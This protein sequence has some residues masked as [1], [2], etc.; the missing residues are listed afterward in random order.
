MIFLA[1]IW[2]LLFYA[3]P[4]Q[5]LVDIKALL[6]FIVPY[7]AA[8]FYLRERETLNAFLSLLLITLTAKTIVYFCGYI[9]KFLLYEELVIRV[10]LTA[11]VVFYPI[12]LLLC[13][14]LLVVH[15]D[16]VSRGVYLVLA[17]IIALSLFWSFGREAWF[18]TVVSTV[19]LIAIASP[20]MRRS[21]IQLLLPAL[22][23]FALLITLIRPQTWSYAI[24]SIETFTLKK[25]GTG[26][27]ET[28][29]VRVIE[30][31]NIH[32]LLVD[33]HTLLIGRG[34]GATWTDRYYPLPKKRDIYSFPLGETEH[35]FTHMVFSK[36][37][38]KFGILGSL[39]FWGA[40]LLPWIKTIGWVKHLEPHGPV[41]LAILLG[42]IGIFAKLELIRVAFVGGF[43]FGFFS[44]LYNKVIMNNEL[45]SRVQR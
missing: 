41:L 31:I 20:A 4:K 23:C 29:A 45:P 24:Q 25:T 13:M 26:E 37:Y 42:C 21:Y 32:K 33:S 36:Y 27:E 14:T 39:L 9:I 1:S 22:L 30:W 15:R 38:L 35:V 8:R 44:C 43:L 40:L 16:L 6:F 3:A 2:G 19:A 10:T 34:M 5:W 18:W 11:D 17:V 28:G 12:L 7:F